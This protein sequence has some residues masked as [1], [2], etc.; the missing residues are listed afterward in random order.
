VERL[1]QIVTGQLARG[2]DD[3]EEALRGE[4]LDDAVVLDLRLV[5]EEVLTNIAKYGHDDGSD[6][7]VLLRLTLVREEA[8]LVF[9]DEGRPFDPLSAKPPGLAPEE[10]PLGGLGI[11]L[12][13]SLTDAAEYSRRG[14]EN[15]LTLRKRVGG[16]RSDVP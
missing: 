7:P 8:T 9:A 3:L 14:S 11:L 13:R 12:V 2:L 15:V 4:G 6:R 1:F 16:R 10:R 5:A